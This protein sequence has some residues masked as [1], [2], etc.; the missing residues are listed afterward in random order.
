MNIIDAERTDE[1]SD[2]GTQHECNDCA[3]FPN[4]NQ[5][6]S[7][8]VDIPHVLAED[9]KIT[10]NKRA[11][12]QACARDS[13]SGGL[14]WHWSQK[15]QREIHHHHSH[16]TCKCQSPPHGLAVPWPMRFVQYKTQNLG[17]SE[18]WSRDD[19]RPPQ[20]SNQLNKRHNMQLRKKDNTCYIIGQH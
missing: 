5:A 3:C 18:C 12:A 11:D 9:A 14:C 17:R 6:D 20:T 10:G 1:R 13:R 16:Y 4:G 19:S 8:D 15:R 7:C 2:T